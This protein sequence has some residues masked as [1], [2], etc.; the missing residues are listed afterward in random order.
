MNTQPHIPETVLSRIWEE[1]RFQPDSLSTTDGDEVQ[2]IRRGRK[3][4]DNGPDFRDA[5]IRIGDRV[6][7]GD[8]E[9][10]LKCAD[11]HA[12]G[13][14]FDPAYNQT[15]LHVVLWP[16][17]QIQKQTQHFLIS[18]ANGETVPTVIVQSCLSS[19]LEEL[20][21]LF[22]RIDERKQQKIQRCQTRLKNIPVEQILSGLQ[23]LGT[24]RLYARARRFET[25][26]EHSSFEQVLYE[27]ICEGL[28]YSSNKRPF[29]ELARCLPLESV[30][31]HLPKFCDN[32]GHY[33]PWIQAMLFGT[34]GLLP[35]LHENSGVQTSVCQPG[36]S[37]TIKYVTELRA[38][39]DMLLPCFDLTPMSQEQW[40]FFR[41]RPSNFPTRRL[42]ALSY[43]I[44]NYIVQPPFESYL[45]LFE[46]L[47]EHP[48]ISKQHTVLLEQTLAVPAAGYWKGRYMFGKSVFPDHDRL[49]LGQSRIRDILI[50]AVLPV[51][52]L[53]ARQ[54]SQSALELQI[55]RLY[56][57]FPAPDLNRT[58]RTVFDQVLAHRNIPVAQIRSAIMYQGLLQL[59]KHYCH[60]PACTHCPF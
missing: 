3:N 31:S 15:T 39:W 22:Q 24:E 7:A 8:V 21:L 16:P 49:F 11:W 1:Q 10:H 52:L 58:T 17:Q 38:L 23:Q 26:L 35:S 28:G 55:L 48:E 50:S 51:F 14:D 45:H 18:K 56:S 54:T 36:D 12:H 59:H 41:L 46:L 33:L 20:L 4:T 57:I 32:P 27:A 6:Y 2:V 42:A 44:L 29:L 43:L 34:A 60:L 47:G 5:L 53:Y 37:E 19:P 40:H 25:W 13:H 30:V 9:L